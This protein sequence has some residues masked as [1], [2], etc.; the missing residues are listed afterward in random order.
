M[1]PLVEETKMGKRIHNN[2]KINGE[3]RVSCF[4]FWT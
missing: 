3:T 2:A 4:H 1:G